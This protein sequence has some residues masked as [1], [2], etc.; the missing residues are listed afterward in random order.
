MAETEN[1]NNAMLTRI[2]LSKGQIYN[3]AQFKML[4]F[5]FEKLTGA[6]GDNIE[7]ELQAMGKTVI[8]PALS[9]DYLMGMAAR[10]CVQPV[11][12]DFFKQLP[13]KDYNKVRAAAR[14]F[15]LSSE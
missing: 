11:G 10:A 12:A 13:L 3:G 7:A 8:V 4:D 1:E 9:G 15:L 14:N 6:D 2:E 5:D